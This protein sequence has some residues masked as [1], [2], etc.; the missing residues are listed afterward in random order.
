MPTITISSL[1][2]RPRPYARLRQTYKQALSHFKAFSKGADLDDPKQ[3]AEFK[4]LQRAVRTAD[5]A[6][7]DH[8]W[9]D[10][11]PEFDDECIR[12]MVLYV[13]SARFN[14]DGGDYQ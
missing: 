10:V 3:Y 1:G 2:N 8:V 14:F 13:F 5:K 4:R 7:H 9:N 6:R 12:P 11:E